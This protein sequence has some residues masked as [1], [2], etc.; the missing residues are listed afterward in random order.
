MDF[1]TQHFDTI[2]TWL[3]V[4]SVIATVLMVISFIQIIRACVKQKDDKEN[5]Q[6]Q[7]WTPKK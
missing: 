4:I 7:S 1:I 3:I 6:P 2:A 5:P